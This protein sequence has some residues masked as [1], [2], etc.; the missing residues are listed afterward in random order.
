M[1]VGMRGVSVFTIQR[2]ALPFS[3]S[4]I[5]WIL[6]RNRFEKIPNPFF[7]HEKSD[8]TAIVFDTRDYDL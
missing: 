4:F 5:K 6:M 1:C 8:G 2:Y 7:H 3:L